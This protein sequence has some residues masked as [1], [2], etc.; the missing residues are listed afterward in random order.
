MED[1]EDPVVV[2]VGSSVEGDLDL[3]QL[4]PD[5]DSRHQD[6]RDQDKLH[7]QNWHQHNEYNKEVEVLVADSAKA[8]LPVLASV[9]AQQLP[10]TCS[11]AATAAQLA[12]ATSAVTDS[13][14]KKSNNSSMPK[15]NM[16]NNHAKIT[17]W[18]SWIV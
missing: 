2:E 4:H 6:F 15:K 9:L 17:I 18:Y 5:Q 11:V 1:H 10:H 7:N 12:L 8:L 14:T 16:L 3:R 13:I